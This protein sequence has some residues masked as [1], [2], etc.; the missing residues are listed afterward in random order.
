MDGAQIDPAEVQYHTGV[1]DAAL[2]AEAAALDEA[3]APPAPVVEE[4]PQPTDQAKRETHALFVMVLG[5]LFG[6]VA[7][8]W[9][10][11]AGEVD[12]LA[13][14]YTDLLLKYFPDGVHGLGPEI[15]ALGVTVA[16]IGPRWK[17]PRVIEAKPE[18]EKKDDATKAA[19]APKTAPVSPQQD[20]I[21]P[22]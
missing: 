1:E 17:K 8:A 2:A 3:T 11:S 18:P 5:P 22:D 14:V 6:T 7:P 10:I 12:A 4:R 16:I 13:E 20:P 9:E 19:A 15:A 21:V